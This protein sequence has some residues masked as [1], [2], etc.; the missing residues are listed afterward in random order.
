MKN[1]PVNTIL[2]FWPN[3]RDEKTKGYL[4]SRNNCTF[5]RLYSY[6]KRFVKNFLV[7]L[8]VGFSFQLFAQDF[9]D[10]WTGYFS[11]SNVQD[12]AS[13][14]GVLYAGAENAVFEFS[15]LDGSLKTRSTINGL[16][17]ED[18]SAIY[19][20]EDFETLLIGYE[21]GLIDVVIEDNRNVLTVVD[22]VNKPSIPP[23]EKR[24]NHFMEFNG[25]VYISTG[26]GISLFDLGRLEFD[27]SYFIG[28]NGSSLNIGQTAILGDY[29]YAAAGSAGVRR[30]LVGNSNIIDF[31]NWTTILSDFALYITN[32]NDALYTGSL[33]RRL[34][35]STDGVNFPILATYSERIIDVSTGENTLN[36]TL[37]NSI[38]LRDTNDQIVRSIATIQDFSNAY[39]STT[40]F[41]NQ[42]YIGT[43]GSGVIQVPLSSNGQIDQLLPNGPLENDIFD[44]EAIANELWA[45]YG[46]YS[47]GYDPF[48]LTEKGASHFVVDS[49]WVNIPSSDINTVTTDPLD[50]PTI[51]DLSSIAINPQNT[52]QVFIPSYYSGLLEIND[53]VP[54][55]L[56][57]DT[58]SP[59]E[60]LPVVN[61]VRGG[62][63]I[64]G[65]TYD[66]QGNL[67]INNSRVRNGLVRVSPGGQFQGISLESVL[68]DFESVSG[69][70]DIAIGADGVVFLGTG[71]SGL[72]AYN[73]SGGALARISGTEG[74]ANFPVDDIR[75]LAIDRGGTL[76]IG[77]R[78][79]LRLLFSPSSIFENPQISSNAIII[80]QDGIPQELLNDQVISE[81]IVDGANNKWVST[82]SSGVFLFSPNGQETL[83]HF[84][85]DNSPLPSNAVQSMSLDPQ[86]GTVYFATNKGLVSFDGSSS[87]P[88]SDLEN[89]IVY[90]NPVRP[91]FNG[92]VTIDGLVARSNV[93]ITDLV[94]NLVYEEVAQAG[95]ITWDTTAFGR[96]KVASGVYL[97]LITGPDA[98][99][100]QIRKLMIVR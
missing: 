51:T 16:S 4:L 25:F 89:V 11:Y 91:T 29:I 63:R 14:N 66:R 30:A 61:G 39:T 90:P 96:Y 2:S 60:G 53:E 1:R 93:K 76:W 6:K 88:A 71:D 34:R 23:T 3:S 84:T 8:L 68:P 47:V 74:A 80:V 52:K 37:E 13:G 48:P 85:E 12:V 5:D 21:N 86:S 26:F 73:P 94:G 57:D 7:L 17:G 67:W 65:G 58:N 18:I 20:S 62:T 24:I 49:G 31:N 44:I 59:L 40:S 92:D 45:V 98:V 79:G 75:A 43:L 10:S 69:Y 82:A 83:Q 33:G 64:N 70:D 38:E 9:S 46:N 72:V 32:F 41:N 36:I 100:T 28:D 35:K 22:I 42:L 81:I 77:T 56:F 54:T 95:N 87:P 55:R 19:Y 99:E 97:I 50:R 15:A 78:R 27:D